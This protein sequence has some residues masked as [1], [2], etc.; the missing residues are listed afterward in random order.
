MKKILIVNGPNI[1]MIGE[2]EPELYGTK[3]YKDLKKYI[4]E[5]AKNSGVKAVVFQSNEEGKIVT[6]IQRAKKKFDAIII[7]AGAYTHTSIAILDALKCAAL[8]T[9]EVHLT[10]VSSREEYRKVSYISEYAV[11]TFMG[12]G[13]EGYKKAVDFLVNDL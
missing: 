12:L 5:C 2:R 10:D 1:N 13:F 8:K 7:N 9:V 11:K 4:L 3:S 6:E